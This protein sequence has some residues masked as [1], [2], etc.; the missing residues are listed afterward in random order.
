MEES[1]HSTL[2]NELL[3]EAKESPIDYRVQKLSSSKASLNPQQQ[4]FMD[5]R[6]SNNNSYLADLWVLQQD[7]ELKKSQ[8]KQLQELTPFSKNT[9]MIDATTGAGPMSTNRTKSVQHSPPLKGSAATVNSKRDKS[10]ISSLQEKELHQKIGK[11]VV[12]KGRSP[13]I[14]S[15]PQKNL[16]TLPAL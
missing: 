6:R 9:S 8:S 4:S 7:A 5:P 16:S 2:R 10:I 11:R 1:K 3:E 14:S 12:K 13:N 15:M